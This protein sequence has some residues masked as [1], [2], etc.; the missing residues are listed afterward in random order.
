M[1][2]SAWQ[3]GSPKDFEVADIRAQPAWLPACQRRYLAPYLCAPI[4]SG[5]SAAL[6]STESRSRRHL[7]GSGGNHAR[8]RASGSISAQS[9][10]RN[11]RCAV[12]R[13]NFSG[14]HRSVYGT[15]SCISVDHGHREACSALLPAGSRCVCALVYR[16]MASDDA[17]AAIF[18]RELRP[19]VDSNCLHAAARRPLDDTYSRHLIW[20]TPSE[21]SRSL[22]LACAEVSGPDELSRG[23]LD[24]VEAFPYIFVVTHD[25][26]RAR[27]AIDRG[28]APRPD[29]NSGTHRQRY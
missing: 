10:C 8:A 21:R 16:S 7:V 27:W 22:A 4:F 17:R 25:Q 6:D 11:G 26:G 19:I 23:S 15:P 29:G 9:L 28:V 24:D 14:Q 5:A 12:L 2:P 13:G 20:S 3:A 18:G 1:G